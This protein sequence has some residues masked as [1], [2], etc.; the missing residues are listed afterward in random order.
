MSSRTSSA[1]FCRADVKPP[2]AHENQ[3][4]EP[5]G[6]RTT[7]RPTGSKMEGSPDLD[8]FCALAPGLRGAALIGLIQQVVFL[9]LSYCFLSLNGCSGSESSSCFRIWG[10]PFD[11]FSSTGQSLRPFQFIISLLVSWMDLT[12]IKYLLL[13]NY[14]HT[15]PTLTIK[16][17][18]FCWFTTYKSKVFSGIMSVAWPASPSFEFWI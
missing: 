4:V 17:P 10:T 15:R 3:W 18:S 6:R 1:N 16:V 2:N 12:S 11:S 7:V 8:K 9:G 14:S 5:V 13:W